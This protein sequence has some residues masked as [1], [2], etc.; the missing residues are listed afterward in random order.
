MSPAKYPHPPRRTKKNDPRRL[1]QPLGLKPGEKSTRQAEADEPRYGGDGPR[2][3]AFFVSHL[4]RDDGSKQTVCGQ[5]WQGWQEPADF[6]RG[7]TQGQVYPPHIPPQ[8]GEAINQCQV[9][10][11]K[12]MQ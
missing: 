5:P 9:C 4:I 1:P 11:R 7:Y 8:R 2:S 3:G 12:A 10:F 6:N